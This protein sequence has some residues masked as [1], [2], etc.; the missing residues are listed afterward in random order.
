M[1]STAT[2]AVYCVL[3]VFASLFGGWLPSLMRLTHMRLQLMMSA[4]GGLMLGIGLFHLLPHA[5][6]PSVPLGDAIFW[7]ML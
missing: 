7:L 5:V 4:V 3:I 2:L 1:P 6:N